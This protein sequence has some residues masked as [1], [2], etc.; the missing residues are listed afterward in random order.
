MSV[1]TEDKT[2]SGTG[3]FFVLYFAFYCYIS[4][5]CL[6]VVNMSDKEKKLNYK[7]IIPCTI[8]FHSA[9]YLSSAPESGWD[10]QV[11]IFSAFSKKARKLP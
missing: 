7:I 8:S 4:C 5:F 11:D 9:K 10:I 1:L 3:C 6:F 2:A